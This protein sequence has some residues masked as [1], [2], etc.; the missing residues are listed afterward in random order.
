MKQR[1]FFIIMVLAVLAAGCS[2]SPVRS[3][4]R[5]AFPV[6]PPE[7]YDIL[8]EPY[9]RVEWLGESGVWREWEGAPESG[10]PEI[11]LPAEWTTPVL[12]WPFWPA[13]NLPPG[14]MRPSGA[15][16]PWD[17][18]GEKLALSWKG[19]V[20][21]LFW[22]ELVQ[23]DRSAPDASG[24]LPWNFDWPR[25]AELLESGSIPESVRENP[26]LAD[27]REIGRKTV[28]SGFDRRRIVPRESSGI[29]I[30]GMDGLWI[31]SSPFAAPVAAR[32][33]G[34]LLVNAGDIADTWVSAGGVLKC[35]ASGWVWMPRE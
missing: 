34:S 27:W 26:W 4:Y 14:I 12:A 6:I 24:R 18:D 11:S 1:Y 13:R 33:D 16:F 5:P 23:A 3:S 2:E 30:P 25:F 29:T 20:P 17:S 15:L 35:S 21:A 22:K 31:N 19:G 10:P 7:W 32:E 9:W 28:R 8:G